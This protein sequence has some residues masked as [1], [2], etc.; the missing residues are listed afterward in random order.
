MLEAL[1]KILKK[2]LQKISGL[3]RDP[4]VNDWNHVKAETV[5][6][7]QKLFI[8][9]QSLLNS[10]AKNIAH[11]KEEKEIPS[12]NGLDRKELFLGMIYLPHKESHPSITS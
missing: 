6:K 1:G 12:K 2:A 5:K 3:V 4:S 7:G 8:T 10:K 11:V 9:Y